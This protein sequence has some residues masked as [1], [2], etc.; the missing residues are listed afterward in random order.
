MLTDMMGVIHSSDN[1][2]FTQGAAYRAMEMSNQQGYS[3]YPTHLTANPVDLT[4]YP[5]SQRLG[6]RH[7][8]Q[9]GGSNVE[10]RGGSDWGRN[11][12]QGGASGVQNQMNHANVQYQTNSEHV[13]TQNNQPCY[14]TQAS[15]ML[16]FLLDSDYDYYAPNQSHEYHRA[17]Y[18]NA[19]PN[20]LDWGMDLSLSN[21]QPPPN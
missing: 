16:S 10:E 18:A 17:R 12:E 6:K 14:T 8:H 3:Q 7:R 21:Y 13:Q 19:P 2:D 9:R 5:R 20:P 1:L 11:F 4:T 15:H